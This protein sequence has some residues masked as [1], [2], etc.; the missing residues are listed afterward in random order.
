[1]KRFTDLKVWQ[2]GHVLMLDIYSETADFPKEE[3]YSLTSQIRRAALSVPANIAEGTKRKSQADYARL[4]NIAEGSLAEV[5]YFVIAARDL[6][7]LGD[8][9]DRDSIFATL[10]RKIDEVGR[11]LHALRTKIEEDNHGREPGSRPSALGSRPSP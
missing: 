8:A 2:A 6:G 7:Y 4:L 5:E 3:R 1:M 11:M 9:A 10:S